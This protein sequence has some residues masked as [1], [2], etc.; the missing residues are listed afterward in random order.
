MMSAAQPPIRNRARRKYLFYVFFAF[1][2]VLTAFT[3]IEITFV[4]EDR[5]GHDAFIRWGG[6]TGFTL[7]LFGFLVGDSQKFLRKW[8]FWVMTAILLVGH[9]AVFAIVLTHV[10]EWKLTWFMV[11]AIEYPLFLFLRDKFVLP[12]GE[13]PSGDDRGSS[14]R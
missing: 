5:W 2:C 12:L 8:W 10:E 6:L 13:A 9:L 7:L 1:L 11:M 14:S 3:L 4:V